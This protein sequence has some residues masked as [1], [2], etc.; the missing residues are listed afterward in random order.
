MCPL[1]RN[2]VTFNY[3]CEAAKGFAEGE[4]GLPRFMCPCL[5]TYESK[6]KR[7]GVPVVHSSEPSEVLMQLMKRKNSKY[8]I[9]Y[10]SILCK[11]TRW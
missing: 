7:G 9:N 2:V 1:E 8:K 4:G 6:E 10:Y 3:S 11:G 5:Q